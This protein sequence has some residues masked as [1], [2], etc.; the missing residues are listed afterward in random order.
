MRTEFDDEEEALFEYAS[1]LRESQTKEERA[2]KRVDFETRFPALTAYIKHTEARGEKMKHEV[3]AA[4]ADPD[5]G[6]TQLEFAW[7]MVDR[8]K[9]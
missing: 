7:Y 1:M 4:L 3:L 8:C 2:A 5:K 6:P 9:D